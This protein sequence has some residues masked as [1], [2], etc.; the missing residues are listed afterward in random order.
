MIDQKIFGNVLLAHIEVGQY[1][2]DWRPDS[3]YSEGVSARKNLGRSVARTSHEIDYCTWL[4]GFPNQLFCSSSKVSDLNIDV[5]DN[6]FIIF[7][8]SDNKKYQLI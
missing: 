2:P 6:A 5:N 4:F 8:Y 3:D 1:L 7:E